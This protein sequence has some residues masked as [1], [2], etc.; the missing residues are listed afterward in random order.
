MVQKTENLTAGS[1]LPE[2]EQPPVSVEVLKLPK[3]A[4]DGDREARIESLRQQAEAEGI[5]LEELLDKVGS[6]EVPARPKELGSQSE[7]TKQSVKSDT[8]MSRALLKGAL[9]GNI[10]LVDISN[11]DG[12]TFQT[13]EDLKKLTEQN[14]RNSQ[15]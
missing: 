15:N 5:T 9:E 6:E 13:V 2:K 4:I 10:D 11:K 14:I 12:I 3:S 8:V 1:N 7:I